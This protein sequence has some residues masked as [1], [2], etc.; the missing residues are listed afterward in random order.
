MRKFENKLTELVKTVDGQGNAEEK[1]TYVDMINYCLN[2]PP[3]GGWTPT[4]MKERL[5]V[6][7]VL[8]DY[9]EGDEVMIEDSHYEIIKKCVTESKWMGKHKDIV[10]FVDE[11]KSMKEHKLKKAK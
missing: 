11:V 1:M 9:T 7:T 5:D 6:E 4:V 2:I 10:L 8:E 3:Q